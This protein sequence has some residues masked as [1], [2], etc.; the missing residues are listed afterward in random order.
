MSSAVTI[1]TC[2][3][4]LIHAAALEA[5]LAPS[6][7][8]KVLFGNDVCSPQPGGVSI[9]ERATCTFTTTVDVDDTRVPAELPVVKCNCLGNLCRS[10][11]D[12]RCREVRSTFHV[13]YRGNAELVNGTVKLATSCVC[14]ASRTALAGAGGIRTSNVNKEFA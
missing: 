8:E 5:R 1:I 3:L 6:A 11:G 14:A 2:L 7:F 12:Y 10:D 13:A 9:G 4:L